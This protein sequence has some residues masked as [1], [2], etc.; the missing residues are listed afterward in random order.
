MEH[1]G[2]SLVVL[3]AAILALPF[4]N[5]KDERARVALFGI[6]I[7]LTWRYVWWRFA[8]TLPPFALRFDSLYAWGFSLVE[9]VA[10]LGWILGFITLSRTR[11]RGREGVASRIWLDRLPRPSRVDVLITTYNE[12]EAT[13]TRTIIG[14]AGIDFP[15]VR[16]C[17][18]DD[19]G[20][21]WLE[22][23]CRS[24]GAHYLTRRDNLHAKAGNINHALQYLRDHADPPEFVATF[25]AD[26]VPHREFLW[27][28]MPLFHDPAVGLI[29]TPQHF[30][31]KDPIQSNLLV[32]NVW[33]DEQCFF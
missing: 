11:D 6:C 16:V 12:E 26:F 25:D 23:L 19:G 8:A 30:F 20:R 3:G 10:N 9:L 22:A 24:K 18:L 13:L 33:P 27:R 29:Q 7:L 2:L 4:L 17:V 5:P 14:A 31:N 32:G 1:L 28:T 21:R 15:G